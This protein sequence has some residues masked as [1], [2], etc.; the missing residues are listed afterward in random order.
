MSEFFSKK[1]TNRV[2]PGSYSNRNNYGKPS[3]TVVEAYG[4][5][6]DFLMRQ[7]TVCLSLFIVF[8]KCPF[9]DF[10]DEVF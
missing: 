10:F 6:N 8:S 5:H 3:H 9:K 2:F 1:E 7:E 4:L